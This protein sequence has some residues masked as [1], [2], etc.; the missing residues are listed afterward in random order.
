MSA[1]A[2]T[3]S[4]AAEQATFL[5]GVAASTLSPLAQSLLAETQTLFAQH[6]PASAADANRCVQ[7][8]R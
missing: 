5:A 3:P 4:S 1:P 7:C 2:A 8:I 6:F